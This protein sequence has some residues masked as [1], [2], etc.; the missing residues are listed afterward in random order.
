MESRKAYLIEKEH[1]DFG[2]YGKQHFNTLTL[3]TPKT[4]TTLPNQDRAIWDPTPV[5]FLNIEYQQEI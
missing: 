2:V 5:L 3:H 1:L 4:A